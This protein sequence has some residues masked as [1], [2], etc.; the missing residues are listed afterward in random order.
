MVINFCDSVQFQ[1][2]LEIDNQLIEQVSEARL[3]GVNLSDTLKWH[4]NTHEIVKK[5]NQRICLLR[6]LVSYDIPK[7]DLLHI[8]TMYVRSV[9]EQSSVVWGSSITES[10]K[11]ALERIQKCSLRL[12]YN[13]NKHRLAEGYVPYSELLTRSGLSCLNTRREKL[14]QKFS[15]RCIQNQKTQHMFPENPNYMSKRR[16]ERFKVPFSYHQRLAKSAIPTMV[17]YLNK[18]YS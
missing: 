2:R 8:Y 10:E 11:S 3:L 1:T 15:D 9:I 13:S 4:N 7:K 12:I 14:M 16:P 17:D 6:N 5:G 18:K